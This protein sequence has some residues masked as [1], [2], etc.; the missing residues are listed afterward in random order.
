MVEMTLV[1]EGQL[2]CAATH[3][4]SGTTLVT[5]APVDN[6]GRGESFSPTDLLATALGSCMLTY[7]GLAA[8]KHG[9]E[10]EGTRLTVKKEMVADPLRRIGRL[11]VEVRLPKPMDG[12]GLRILT[13][14]VTTCPVK[15]SISEAIQVPIT[16]VGHE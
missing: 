6:H 9:W 12:E 1:Y 13:N 4:P 5:D 10:L 7:V 14:A 16:F 3:G 15:L 8:T 2:R 11:S